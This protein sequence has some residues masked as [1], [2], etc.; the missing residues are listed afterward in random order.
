LDPLTLSSPFVLVL[1]I[2]S[3]VLWSVW[4]NETWS[5][6][7]FQDHLLVLLVVDQTMPGKFA[8]EQ[9]SLRTII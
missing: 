2:F 3:F 9:M 1:I 7:A 8:Q 6:E 5:A 4:D